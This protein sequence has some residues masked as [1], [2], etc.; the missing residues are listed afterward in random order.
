M[1]TGFY[2]CPRCAGPD[3][4]W[5]LLHFQPQTQPWEEHSQPSS[6][7]RLLI[8]PWVQEGGVEKLAVLGLAEQ[9]CGPNEEGQRGRVREPSLEL[10]VYLFSPPTPPIFQVCFLRISV[11]S[12]MASLLLS[13]TSLCLLL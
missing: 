8:W 1:Q 10:F 6:E 4:L 11:V 13:E 9:I 12:S 5:S 3:L 7:W 2:C